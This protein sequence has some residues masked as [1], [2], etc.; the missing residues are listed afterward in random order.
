MW[1]PITFV[2]PCLAFAI[3]SGRV[4]WVS[5][6]L[7]ILIALAFLEAVGDR[8]GLFG[9]PGTA[10]VSWGNFARFIHYT[11]VVNSFL[12]TA[13]IP[14]LAVLATI[15]ETVLGLTMLLGIQIRWMAAGSAA[16]FFLF[17]TAMTIS[18]LSQFSY[19]VYLQC[20]AA[21]T[22]SITG[23]SFISFDALNARKPPKGTCN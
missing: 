5:S 23:A 7:R 19:A 4:R 8:F 17:A 16:L 13:M 18:G 2:L 11:G 6:V 10:G 21:A 20:A 14:L 15:C 22:L 1:Y 3:T 12:P 9:P